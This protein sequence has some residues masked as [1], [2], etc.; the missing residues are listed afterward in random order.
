MDFELKKKYDGEAWRVTLSGE[1]DIYNS[2]ELKTKL[3][4]LMEEHIADVHADCKELEY[5]DST[6]LGALV[7]ALKHIKSH[8]K[9]LHL[10]NVKPNIS[11]LFRITSLDKVF[12]ISADS[13]GEG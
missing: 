4:Q 10:S 6:G 3:T 13:M 12:I 2:A 11:K 8:E 5:I 7:G 1:I 9:E